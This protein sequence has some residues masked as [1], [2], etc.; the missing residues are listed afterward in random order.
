MLQ[1]T[2]FNWS[3]MMAAR[4]FMAVAEAGFGPGPSIPVILFLHALRARFAV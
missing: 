2:A 3:G 1:A 4:F